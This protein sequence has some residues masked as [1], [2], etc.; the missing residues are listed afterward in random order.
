[1]K[2]SKFFI[3]LGVLAALAAI[4]YLLT[5]NR[6]S[7]EVLIGVVDANNVV[8]SSKI[9]GRI[10]RL[11]VDEGTPVKQGDLIA[12]IDSGELKAQKQAAE[13]TIAS[14]RARVSQARASATQA[15]GETAS[16]L[17][18]AQARLQ[19]A[20]SAST[21]AQ[22][23]L[24]R[25]RSDAARLIEL[26]K[27]GVASKADQE[28]SDAQ[29]R[30]AQAAAQSAADQVRAAEAD[31]K[32]Y[33]ARLEQAKAARSTLAGSEEDVRTAEA[34]LSE[35]ETRLG[36]TQVVSPVNGVVNVRA[37]REGEVVNPGQ[38][39]VTV[40]DYG[41]TWVYAPLPE[42]DAGAINL[43]DTLTVKYPW[44]ATEQGKVFYKA[45]EADFATQRDVSRTKRDIKTI[46]I[47]VRVQNDQQGKL[48]P[49]MTADVLV[50]RNK[51]GGK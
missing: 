35:A 38:A 49:G 5:T 7:D 13:T 2:P 18:N 47:K 1:V 23:D 25:V 10:E 24:E 46:A 8:V 36:Y 45:A 15:E 39:I 50:P 19:A 31:V 44:G 51:Q 26:A 41:D 30:V 27:Q 14:Y 40:V 43:G 11:A 3:F 42:T 48:V 29:L 12:V 20:R 4:Y 6:S 21:Q 28:R 17:A 34:Q 22:A 9:L 16:Q 37:A 32:T 33:Q